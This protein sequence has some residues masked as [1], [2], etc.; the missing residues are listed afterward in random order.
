M[1]KGGRYIDISGMTSDHL[2]YFF[3]HILFKSS[4]TL[5]RIIFLQYRR[6]F[7]KLSLPFQ[8]ILGLVMIPTVA[9]SSLRRG[10]TKYKAKTFRTWY[11]FLY[12]KVNLLCVNIQ[13]SFSNWCEVSHGWRVCKFVLFRQ[14]IAFDLI[15]HK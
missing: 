13:Y 7:L 2:L 1:V 3:E 10:T 6:R 11:F 5:F 15:H 4:S 9:L 8:L 14:N 12:N